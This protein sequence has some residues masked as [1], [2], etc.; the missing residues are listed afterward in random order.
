MAHPPREP[1]LSSR[2]RMR[3]AVAAGGDRR[4]PLGALGA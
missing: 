4:G 1:D 3:L 2:G